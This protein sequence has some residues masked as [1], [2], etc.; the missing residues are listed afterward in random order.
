MKK[1]QHCNQ[2]FDDDTMFCH[3]DGNPLIKFFDGKPSRTV[4]PLQN[5]PPDFEIPTQ[6]I[7]RTV[8]PSSPPFVVSPPIVKDNSKWLYAL[9]GGL[10]ALIIAMGIGFLFLR[11]TGDEKETAKTSK[12]SEKTKKEDKEDEEAE[13]SP[14]PEIKSEK[15]LPIKSKM[16]ENSMTE[17]N[18]NVYSGNKMSPKKDDF[19]LSRNFNQTFSGAM[20]ADSVS[21]RLKRSGSSLG[22]RVFS[23]RSATEITVSGSIDN[24]GYFRMNEFSDIGVNTGFYSGYISPDGTMNGIW[25]TPEGDKPRSMYL[26]AK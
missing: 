2:T 3:D 23:R 8:P 20:G 10:I 22:G 9:I 1:C 15:P 16:P 26:Q 5:N 7:S 4:I 13:S 11:N 21:M 24:V 19:R 25:T 6:I 18:A 12:K 17:M 14:S